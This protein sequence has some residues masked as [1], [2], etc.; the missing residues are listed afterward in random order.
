MNWILDHADIKTTPEEYQ[1]RMVMAGTAVEGIAPLFDFSGVVIGSVLACEKHENSDHLKVCTVDAGQDRPLNIV[2]GAPNV[3]EGL[4]VPTALIGA[5]LPGMTIKRGKI[6]GVESEGML[7]SSAELQI[8]QEVYPSVGEAG[9]LILNEEYKPGDDFLEALGLNDRVVD[10]DILANRPDCLS[11]WGV[12]RETAAVYDVP[13]LQGPPYV[14]PAGGDIGRHARIEVFNSGLCPRYM[15]RVVKNIRLAPSPLWL[16]ARLHAAG[17]RSINNIVDITNY[18]MLETGHPMHAFDLEQVR[19]RHII[20]REALAGESLRTLDGKDHALDGGELLICDEQGP[21]GLAGIMGG[22]ESEITENTREILFECAAFDRT[23]TRVVSRRLGI[24][25]ESGARF[26]RGVNP[27]TVA[28][29]MDRACQLVEL[30]DAGDVLSGTIDLYPAP[31]PEKQL[32]VSVSRIAR[33]AGADI[34]G[35]EMERLLR[36]LDFK[37][38]RQGDLM[39]VTVPVHRGDIEMEADVCEEVLRLAGYDRIPETLLRGQTAAGRDSAFGQMKRWAQRDLGALGYDE[40]IN[41]SFTS[42]K[43]LDNLGLSVNDPRLNPVRIMNPLGEDTAVMRTTLAPDMLKTLAYNLNQ[44]NEE[45]LLYEFGTVYQAEPK[46]DEGLFIER[47]AL[48]LGAYGEG[49]DFYRVRD[50]VLSLLERARIAWDLE[51]G[52]EP[53]HH[54]GRCAR[55]L[56]AGRAL[57]VLGE[58]HPAAAERFGMDR[59]CMIAEID[60]EAVQKLA[61]PLKAVSALPRT[62]AV[63]RDLALVIDQAQELLP[64]LREI[65]SAGGRLVEEVRLF[66]VFVGAQVGEGRKSAAFSLLI[67]HPE[68]TLEEAEINSL[69]DKVKKRLLERFGAQIRA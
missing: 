21:T 39:K 53:Y 51:K 37:V 34:S 58:V 3:R 13:F 43:Q 16:R 28:L 33:R 20:V 7:C 54:P 8:P 31:L 11:V 24:R 17:M 52:G 2:C 19:G 69:L 10:F 12:A 38:T 1:H 5:K 41:F 57:A 25:T 64:V 59:R 62:P 4:L 67:R 47:K 45:A 42:Q 60:F 63:R 44:R 35:E 32:E 66:D 48:C 15:G 18:V 23:L 40:I 29:A 6:R 22:L 56:S 27:K 30:L 55:I 46:T 50:T 65:K 36:R 26:E 14:P 9:L 61:A 49:I 68:K